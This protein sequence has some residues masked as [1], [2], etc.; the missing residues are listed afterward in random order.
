MAES[1]D[2]R[3]LIFLTSSINTFSHFDDGKLP[4]PPTETSACK[5]MNFFCNFR[6]NL[7]G[8]LHYVFRTVPV[9][10]LQIRRDIRNRKTTRH[11]SRT[12]KKKFNRKKFVIATLPTQQIDE[13]IFRLWIS[14]RIWSK[15]IENSSKKRNVRTRTS[16]C[17][18]SRKI[19]HITMF[20]LKH[21]QTISWKYPFDKILYIFIITFF[22]N[23]I[24]SCVS[25]FLERF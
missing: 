17:E 25:N 10:L 2:Y 1:S 12:M 18:N 16:L 15:K 8:S 21:S 5:D 4:P 19:H 7:F 9:F 6:I 20:P 3:T 23:P 24:Q 13:A 22:L 14:L 11:E